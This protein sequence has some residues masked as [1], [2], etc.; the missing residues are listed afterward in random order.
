MESAPLGG[1]DETWNHPRDPLNLSLLPVG[2]AIEQ[3]LGVGMRGMAEE[4]CR[5]RY[6]FERSRSCTPMGNSGL[7]EAKGS[8]GM[9]VIALPRMRAVRSAS[10][11]R[12]KSSP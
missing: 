4:R 9:T 11:M 12:N 2:Q 10:G 3:F 8:C 6:L 1:I 7:S 5:R